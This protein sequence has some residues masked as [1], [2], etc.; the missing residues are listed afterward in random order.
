MYD[1][2]IFLKEEIIVIILYKMSTSC[3]SQ[4]GLN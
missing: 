1:S 3:I 2:N 4:D